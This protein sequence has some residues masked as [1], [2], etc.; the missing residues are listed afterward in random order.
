[1]ILKRLNVEVEAHDENEIK[2]LKKQGFNPIFKAPVKAVTAENE[3]GDIVINEQ[4][5]K[6]PKPKIDYTSLTKK[7]LAAVAEDMG[8]SVKGLN[9]SQIIDVITKG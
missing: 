7:E 4:P 2:A 3:N 1:M 6:M 9:K 5:E 8:Y